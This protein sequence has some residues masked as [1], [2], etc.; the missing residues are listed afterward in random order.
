MAISSSSSFRREYNT[1]GK[2]A[3]VLSSFHDEFFS[4]LPSEGWSP[5]QRRVQQWFYPW[6]WRPLLPGTSSSFHSLF[7]N[8]I[9]EKKYCSILLSEVWGIQG[10]K[11]TRLIFLS[12]RPIKLDLFC[13]L[14]RRRFQILNC[15]LVWNLCIEIFPHLKLKKKTFAILRTIISAN[16]LS[17]KADFRTRS[18]LKYNWSYQSL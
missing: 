8:F 18:Y 17:K 3:T 10:G 4:R 6:T 1:G 13:K 12:L 2:S 9:R 5:V 16:V 7:R 14:V 15:I 11:I